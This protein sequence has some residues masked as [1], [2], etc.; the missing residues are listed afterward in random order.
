MLGGS[1]LVYL[2]FHEAGTEGDDP[3]VRNLHN[4]T[5]ELPPQCNGEIT[6]PKAWFDH[7]FLKDVGLA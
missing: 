2:D 5:L 1:E 6:L 4:L 7:A 3:A